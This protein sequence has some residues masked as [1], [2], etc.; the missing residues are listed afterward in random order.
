MYGV[1]V[2]K[3]V[4]K[5]LQKISQSDYRKIKAALSHLANNP[6]PVGYSKLKNRSGYRIRIGNYRIIY[7][8]N[9]NQLIVLIITIAHRKDVYE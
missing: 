4:L 8:I 1:I 3:S 7:E 6:R 2:E 9:D 5:Q